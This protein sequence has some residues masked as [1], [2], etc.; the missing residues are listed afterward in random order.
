MAVWGWGVHEAGGD[1]ARLPAG[2]AGPDNGGREGCGQ[3]DIQVSVP[4]G[5]MAMKAVWMGPS[6][7]AKEVAGAP[8][9]SLPG[10][11]GPCKS[12]V[13]PEV[14]SVP[15]FGPGVPEAAVGAGD[16]SSVSRAGAHGFPGRPPPRLSGSV[17]CPPTVRG[18]TRERGQVSGWRCGRRQ[19]VNILPGVTWHSYGWAQPPAT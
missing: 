17:G 1:L 18:R 9:V 15:L 2:L 7:G 12:V 3:G 6:R 19:T 8:G 11:L 5:G 16:A 4:E 14:C 10:Q 13:W